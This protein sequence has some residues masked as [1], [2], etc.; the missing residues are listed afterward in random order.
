MPM[1]PPTKETL[2]GPGASLL[3]PGE[4][5]G[6]GSISPVFLYYFDFLLRVNT[7]LTGYET[8]HRP[9]QGCENWQE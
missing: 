1:G 2:A 5:V 8:T 9:C 6:C 4:F 3:S 7:L